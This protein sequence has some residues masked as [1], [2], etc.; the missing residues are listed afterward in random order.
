M[1]MIESSAENPLPGRRLPSLLS[2]ELR[3]GGAQQTLDK[4]TGW[5][6]ANM[7]N[8]EFL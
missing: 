8:P 2:S 6:L 7:A 4:V 5:S 1:E 3:T